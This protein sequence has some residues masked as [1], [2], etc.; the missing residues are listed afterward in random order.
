MNDPSNEL[1][2]GYTIAAL[3]F[4]NQFTQSILYQ[5]HFHLMIKASV[6]IR[7]AI[8]DRLYCKTLTVASSA[9]AASGT[10]KF[11]NF[12]AVDL[13]RVQDLLL[14]LYILWFPP[15]FTAL[16][17]LLLWFQIGWVCF[18]GLA[19]MAVGI[20]SNFSIGVILRILMVSTS[21]HELLSQFTS[22]Q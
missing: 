7:A 20:V 8:I 18:V 11:V 5:Q 4:V 3:Y 15:L 10:G 14:Q 21:I 2:K 17:V 16:S 19:M 13:Q 9:M 12:L 22:V 1:W 6:R